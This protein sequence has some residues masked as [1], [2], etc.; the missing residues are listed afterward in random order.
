MTKGTSPAIHNLAQGGSIQRKYCNLR[1][2]LKLDF[3]YYIY[4][5]N[6]KF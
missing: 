2:L 5:I 3:F 4:Y 1:E 6:A